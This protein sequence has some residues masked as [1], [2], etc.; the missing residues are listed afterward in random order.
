MDDFDWNCGNVLTRLKSLKRA[1]FSKIFATLE[2]TT[3]LS[4]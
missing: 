2:K 1:D 3:L 4:L